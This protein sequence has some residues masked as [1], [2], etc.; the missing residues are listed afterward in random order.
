[1]AEITNEP[2]AKGHDPYEL[3]KSGRRSHQRNRRD[4][5]S[6]Y[7]DLLTDPL[8]LLA[9]FG[10]CRLACPLLKAKASFPSERH[11]PEMLQNEKAGHF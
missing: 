3:K 4:R 1:M 5:K 11:S 8:A 9:P 7:F 6:W 2:H 10:G